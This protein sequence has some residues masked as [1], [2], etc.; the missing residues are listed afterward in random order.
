MARDDIEDLKHVH[1]T[2]A[3]D[4]K[5]PLCGEHGAAH[6]FAPQKGATEEMV[7]L[8]DERSMEICPS[9]SQAFRL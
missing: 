5:N 1:F 4:V 3:S 6:V 7:R 9:L 2:I 8:L